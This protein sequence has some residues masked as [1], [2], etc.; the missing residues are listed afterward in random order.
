MTFLAKY[1]RVLAIVIAAG[2][3]LALISRCTHQAEA[4]GY[5]R[6][7][8]EMA[9]QVARANEA[10][11]ARDAA[12]RNAYQAKESRWIGERHELQ[13][14]ISDL[15]GR[16]KPVRLCP[17]VANRR[18][19]PG[20]TTAAGSADRAGELGVG[21]VPA[22]RDIGPDLV[23]IAGECESYRRRLI[24]LKGRWPL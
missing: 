24:E 16:I 15:A 10:T 18:E 11:A 6:A 2:L 20:A 17:P 22:E 13:T 4:R 9:G 19:V 8:A 3:A 21:A 7:R 5:D 1:W 12:A 14:Q 23:R